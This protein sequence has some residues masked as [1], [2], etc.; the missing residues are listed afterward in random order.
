LLN[1]HYFSKNP[2]TGELIDYPAFTDTYFMDMYRKWRDGIRSHHKDALLLLQYPTLE[3]PPRIKGTS[4]DDPKMGFSPHWYDG[5]TLMTKKWNRTWNVDVIGVLRGRYLH[6]A[7]AIKIG[8]TAIRNCFK[9]Q[10]AAL[11]QEGLDR[12]G[13]HPCVLTEFGIPYDMDGK[14][15]YKSGDY[16]SQLS[17]LD[18]N[19][20]GVEGAAMEGHC[21]WLYHSRNDHDR[22]DQW[23]GEDL[24]IY[25]TDDRPLPM[26]PIPRSEELQASMASLLK[27]PGSQ[28][29]ADE[30]AVTPAN[31]QRTLTNPSI[32]SERGSVKTPELTNTPGYRAAEAFVRPSP[33]A[34]AGKIVQYGFDLRACN[35]QLKLEATSPAGEEAPTVIFLPEFHFPKDVCVVEVSSGKWEISADDEEGAFVQRLKWWHVA[36]TQ[37]ISVTGLVRKH[38]VLEGTA[39]EMG[40]LEQCQ[41]GYG[42]NTANCNAM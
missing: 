23:N 25:S 42:I 38:S 35:F 31:L 16:S 20:F 26:S 36:G 18:A 14:K 30:R 5:I 37:T 34:V 9:D 29:M 7:F 28:G 22:G 6:P 13:N 24:S 32:M 39:E 3:L 15:A 1:K 4:D 40:Y 8:E 10:L 41:R 2:R 17:A 19:Y 27:A 33:V 12:M 21:L 11:R